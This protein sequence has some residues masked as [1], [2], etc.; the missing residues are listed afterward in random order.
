MY[1][2]WDEII[3]E[4]SDA[5]AGRFLKAIMKYQKTGEILSLS[6]TERLMYNVALKQAKQDAEHVAEISKI[7][8][9]ARRG[10]Q[11]KTNESNNNNSHQLIT[12]DDICNELLSND[13]Q[14]KELRS[15]KLEKEI[16]EGEGEKTHPNPKTIK[17]RH[18]NFQHVFLTDDEFSRIQTDFPDWQKRIQKL[19]DYLEN[20]PSKHY[21][22]HNL[23]IRNWANRD[24]EEAKQ[25][26]TVQIRQP[27]QNKT[28]WE[29]LK[30][31]GLV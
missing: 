17:H 13:D 12:N 4:L 31:K 20:N 6:G 7:R 29:M 28:A 11:K 1:I 21:A 18:G 22:N 25:K 9:D 30:E 8:S 14:I 5:E 15:K 16:K 2:A 27:S 3:E 10:T 23:T 26:Q 19:D 24:A